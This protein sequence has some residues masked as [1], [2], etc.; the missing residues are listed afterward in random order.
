MCQDSRTKQ[1]EVL[2][3]TERDGNVALAEKFNGSENPRERDKQKMRAIT[4]V[5]GS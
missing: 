2:C 4:L 3:V 1:L 5:S